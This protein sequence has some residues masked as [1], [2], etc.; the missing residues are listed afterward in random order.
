[1]VTARESALAVVVS[2]MM[3]GDPHQGGATWAVL[4]YVLGL[5]ALGHRVTV[6][7]SVSDDKLR[8]PSLSKSTA[9][10]YFDA[11]M[12]AFD[13]SDNGCFLRAGSTETIG[14]SYPDVLRASAQADL[15]M[16]IGGVLTDQ[17]LLSGP[18]R[19]LYVDVDPAFTQLWHAAE[20]ID[21]HLGSHDAFATVGL[22]I[23]EAN[24]SVPTCGVSWI[25]TVPPVV[26]HEWEPAEQV[27]HDSFTSV[28][29]WRG[30]GSIRHGAVHYGQRAHSMRQLAAIPLLS[31]ECFSVAFGIHPDE[32]ADLEMLR[33]TG[34]HLLDPARVASTPRAYRDFVRGSKGEIGVA[35]SGYVASR[36]GWLSDRSCCYLASGRPVV[37][38]ETG[39]SDAFPTGSGILTFSTAEEAAAGVDQVVSDYQAERR[40]ARDLAV[41]YLN[42]AVVLPRLLDAALR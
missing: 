6:V 31:G 23:G 38:Q 19:R 7:E 29:N 32:V 18:S 9:G 1:M 14:M 17:R 24:C 34:W 35:K 36:C 20:G 39:L 5:R 27:V 25:R 41:E 16:N 2:G 12:K 37:V 13:L 4:Q 30:Y 33:E 3:A 8:D 11:V 26:L 21:M 15:L 42:S 28:G 40:A 22:R 10:R